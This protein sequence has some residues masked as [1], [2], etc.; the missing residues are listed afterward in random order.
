MTGRDH[1]MSVN[2]NIG[3]SAVGR[4]VPCPP[5]LANKRVLIRHDGAHGV[6]RP[7]GP[8]DPVHGQSY[9]LFAFKNGL[10]Q[11]LLN[12]VK[13]TLQQPAATP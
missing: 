8:D 6:T 9:A 11:K 12:D 13:I 4:A 2:L 7:T 10:C 1:F 5:P 3:T